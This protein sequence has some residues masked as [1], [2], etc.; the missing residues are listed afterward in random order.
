MQDSENTRVYFDKTAV[1]FDSL[2]EEEDRLWYYVNR[3]FR[4]ALYDRVRLT[5]NEMTGLSDFTL[6]DIGCGSGRN[7]VTFLRAGARQVVGIDF[8]ESMLGLAK[9]YSA[10]NGVASQC[11]FVL[12][13]ALTYPFRQKFDIVVALGVFD[14]IREPAAL[15]RRMAGVAGH[16]VIASFPAYTLI[17]GTQR[18]VRYWVKGCPVYFQ[19]RKRLRGICDEVGLDDY[20]LLPCGGVGNLLVAQVDG[21]GF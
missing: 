7:S 13:D 5:V 1:S 6:L 2:Y 11:E 17:R 8:A 3:V 16:K 18:K 19:S 15:L 21:R 14:Y 20:R 10:A 12:G 9:Q 4:P